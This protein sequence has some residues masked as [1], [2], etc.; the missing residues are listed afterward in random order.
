VRLNCFVAAFTAALIVFSV[1]TSALGKPPAVSS[2][3]PAGAQQGST[4]EIAADPAPDPWPASAWSGNSAIKL[5]PIKDKKGVYNAIIAKDAPLGPHLI[6]IHNTD[7]ASQPRM[8]FI[9]LAGETMEK[10]P[11]DSLEKAQYLK[12]IP[13]VINGRLDKAGDVDCYSIQAEEDDWIVAQCYAYSVDSPVDAFLHLIDENKTKVAFA[14]DTQ[15]IDPLLVYQ[16]KKG[17]T[18]T[19]TIA[20]LRFPYNSTTRLQGNAHSVYRLTISTGAFAR[21]T[22]PLGVQRAQKTPVHLVG[23]GFEKSGTTQ[24]T[25]VNTETAAGTDWVGGIGLASPVPVIVGN[26]AGHRETEPNNSADS[27][28]TIAWPS[29]IH[30][31]ISEVNDEDRFGIEVRKGDKLRLRLRASQFDS[32][33]DPVLRVEDASGKQLARD[34][35]SGE[36]QD[37]KLD[38]IAPA[39]GKYLLAVSDLIRSGSNAHFYRLEVDRITPSLN[40]TFTPD[41]L[42]LEP[43]KS[44]VTTVT[45]NF[46]DGYKGSPAIVVRDLPEGVSAQIPATEKGG[47]VKVV[48]VA[49]ESTKPASVPLSLLVVEPGTAVIHTAV[50]PVG[51]DKAGGER[52]INSV[53]HLWL[54][55]KP[56]PTHKLET[57]SE[58]EK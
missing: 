51:M 54:T 32:A 5:K 34:D 29:A 36:R 43:G 30:G 2:L 45:I 57:K 33:L 20:G 12:A 23:W 19:V 42:V 4:V 8:F 37:A 26:L 17:G 1:W 16:V 7:G 53:P 35:D 31:H 11:N 46:A 49:A 21:N 27:V 10:E 44:A 6:R 3:Y 41:S 15:N 14:P 55:V 24:T 39:D 18:F 52:L 56:K 47:A 58:E 40:A 13:V 25:V 28:L 48:F 38:W 22:S 9:G 50:S